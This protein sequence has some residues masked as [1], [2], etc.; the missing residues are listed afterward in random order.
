MSLRFLLGPAGSGKTHRC[1]EE[2]TRELAGEGWDA[3]PPLY[4]LV[5][6]QATF[7][8]ERALLTFHPQ[9]GATARARVLS[10]KR[11]A[12]LAL[13]EAGGPGGRSLGELGRLLALSIVLSRRREALAL[14]GEAAGTEGF[15]ESAAALLS[16]LQAYGHDP[17][18]LARAARDVADPQL[19]AKLEEF[20]SLFA[21]YR[22]FL[23]N[24]FYDADILFAAARR[25]LRSSSLMRGARVWIDGFAGFTPQEYDLLRPVLSAADRVTVALCVDPQAAEAN[26]WSE[27]PPDG[28]FHPV[29]E[30]LVQLRKVAEGEGVPVEPPALL[31]AGAEGG[32][33]FRGAP[34]LGRLERLMVSDPSALW[35]PPSP[36]GERLAPAAP[37]ALRVVEAPDPRREVEEAARQILRWVRDEGRSFANIGVVLRDLE[38]YRELIETTF[39]TWGIPFFLDS[40]EPAYHHP[41][42]A[43][44]RAA[45][46]VAASGFAGEGVLRYLKS[47]FAPVDDD[48]VDRLENAALAYGVPGREWERERPFESEEGLLEAWRAA[49][50]PLRALRERWLRVFAQGRAPA[51]EAVGVLEEFF[52]DV[53]AEARLQEWIDAALAGSDPLEARE[54]TQVWNALVGLLEEIA[55]VMGES[56]V[57]PDEFVQAVTLGLRRLRLGRVPPRLDQ[58]LVGSV[59]RSRQPDLECVVILG[60]NAG[61]FPAGQREDAIF[62]DAEREALAAAGM[63]LAPG[64]RLRAFHERYLAYIALTRA[65]RSLLLTYSRSDDGGKPLKPSPVVAWLCGSVEGL[66]V[67]KASAGSSVDEFPENRDG[68]ARWA[69][70]TLRAAMDGAAGGERMRDALAVAAWLRSEKAPVPRPSRGESLPLDPLRALEYSNRSLPLSREEVEA[71]FG[72]GPR[73]SPT[74]LEEFAACPFR[75]FV[76]RGLGI[77]ER[78]V[79]RLAPSDLGILAHAV[80]RRLV[81]TIRAQGIDWP[82]LT[83]E[84]SD[85]LVAAAFDEAVKGEVGEAFEE[86]A[87]GR[88]A[89]RRMKRTLQAVAWAAGALARRGAFRPFAVEVGF[90]EGMRLPALELDAGDG[91]RA[92]VQ[93]RI[94]RIDVAEDGE[95]RRYVRV[96]DYKSSGRPF[97]LDA[98]V[99]GIDLQL[100]VYAAVAARA[101]EGAQLAG[102]LYQPVVDPVVSR[103]HPGPGSDEEWLR[104]LKAAGLI[105]DAWGVPR[106]M[107]REAAGPSPLLPLE[108]T[109]DG[110]LG[111]RS[112]VAPPERMEKLVAYAARIASLLARRALDGETA[113]APYQLSG[114]TPC[115]HCPYKPVCQFDPLVEG[116]AYRTLRPLKKEEA[117][118][119]I[120][121]RLAGEGGSDLAV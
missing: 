53:G 92:R 23:G 29:L 68:I 66:R 37:P 11:L 99:Y 1:L 79:R 38:P 118:S 17:E 106:M 18:S 54:H 97:R 44:L 45:L 8:M 34:F 7:Q 64:S 3:G 95:G 49:S 36:G 119:E 73:F 59:E 98:L 91:R 25:T 51:R 50:A 101:L 21:A 67:E 30:T 84:R 28:L 113:I 57:A 13:G 105:V 104:E 19:G 42:A 86:S 108:F 43:L 39:P 12:H 46:E 16:E 75:F 62:S 121:R 14:F 100:G 103:K 26:G 77:K 90:G 76:S 22:A 82:G 111:K 9:V 96:I 93:G 24:R 74:S 89:L 10:F 120:E 47:G 94:D 70:S 81:E 109:R 31:A 87:S 32:P 78:P 110:S 88:Y 35:G 33:R 102:C 41:A 4:L 69:A 40:K 61:L 60:C 63:R 117:W 83:R 65:S 107:D 6:E 71:L 15:V 116:N 115:R 52:R 85:E 72:S 27:G 114:E 56:T 5:P 55:A 2:I 20:A 48:A 58:V 80:L 112:S